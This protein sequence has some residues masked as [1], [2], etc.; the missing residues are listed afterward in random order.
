MAPLLGVVFQA[1]G[2]DLP[3]S[4]ALVAAFGVGHAGIIVLL[5]TFTPA[6]KAF[7]KWDGKSKVTAIAKAVIGAL[8][9][10]ISAYFVYTAVRR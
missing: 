6:V 7:L 1:A 2:A 4:M 3:R 8:F 5:G 10:L 9:I